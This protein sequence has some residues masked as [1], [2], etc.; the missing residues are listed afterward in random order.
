MTQLSLQDAIKMQDQLITGYLTEDFQKKIWAAF[1]SYGEDQLEMMKKRQEICLTVQGPV[2][3]KFG[4]DPDRQGVSNSS[5]AFTP[6]MNA[7]EQVLM[8]NNLMQYLIDPGMQGKVAEGRVVGPPGVIPSRKQRPEPEEWLDSNSGKVWIVTGGGDK[9]G[10]VVRNGQDT[11]SAQLDSRLGTGAIVEQMDREG[12]RLKFEKMI[13]SGPDIGWISISFKNK[14]IVEPLWFVPTDEEK[15]TTE[16]YK[17]VHDRVAQ[18]GTPSKD[19]KMIGAA[20]KG[21]IVKGETIDK[22]GVAWLKTSAHNPASGKVEEAYMMID[23]ASV[24]LGQ[25]LKKL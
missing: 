25:L 15:K 20:K 14:P 17:V 12:D 24:G 22:D 4:F 13:G 10:I 18:R 21:D 3:E 5:K 19:G 11:N 16:S 8:R 6:E 7:N 9:G 2:I 23:G 1:K